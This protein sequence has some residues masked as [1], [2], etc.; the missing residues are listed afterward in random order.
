MTVE[1][2]KV[3][4]NTLTVALINLESNSKTHKIDKMID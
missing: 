2:D 1:Q 3:L 4:K